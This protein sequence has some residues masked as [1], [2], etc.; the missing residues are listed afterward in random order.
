MRVCECA[1]GT[2]LLSHFWQH[3]LD[4]RDEDLRQSRH[5]TERACAYK[6][7]NVGVFVCVSVHV[8]VCAE[9]LGVEIA[10]VSVRSKE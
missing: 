9:T 10:K 1:C 8:R 2:D 7:L 4:L 6:I 3:A 5:E